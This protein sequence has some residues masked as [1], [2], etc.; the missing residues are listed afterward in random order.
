MTALIEFWWMESRKGQHCDRFL[1]FCPGKPQIRALASVLI[2][3]RNADA[4]E[5]L[6]WFRCSAERILPHG[7]TSIMP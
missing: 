6:R 7:S 4:Q 1:V 5:D 2:S 3:G